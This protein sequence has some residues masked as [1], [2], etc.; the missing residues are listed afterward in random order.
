MSEKKQG[1]FYQAIGRRKEATTTVR[2]FAGK[3]ESTVNGTP[4]S[5]YFPIDSFQAK[6]VL[7]YRATGTEDKFYFVAR[8]EGGGKVG[9]L[10]AI[11]LG[12]SR[13]L[14]LFNGDLRKP[15]RDAGLMTR[16]PRE[17][18]RKKY[19]LKKARKRPQ[20]SKR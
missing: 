13:A 20:Y 2:L 9:Q 18:E 8:A 1:K 12:I 4:V 5:K 17:K 11:V 7:P 3:G 14:V 10:D 19:F 16:N 15:L 6:L